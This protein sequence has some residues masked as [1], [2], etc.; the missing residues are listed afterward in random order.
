MTT[1]EELPGPS[2]LF[3]PSAWTD[4]S[5]AF[6]VGFDGSPASRA[7]ARYGAIEARA[8]GVRLTLVMVLDRLEGV[9]TRASRQAD[10][11]RWSNVIADRDDLVRLDPDLDVR[12]DVQVGDAAERLAARSSGQAALVVGQ[13]LGLGTTSRNVLSR[14]D[15]PVV[16]V[17]AGWSPS[18]RPDPRP[19]LL[20]VVPDHED[21]T[22]RAAQAFAG[23]RA[24]RYGVPLRVVTSI[25]SGPDE[26]AALL[27][28]VGAQL[29]VL[30]RSTQDAFHPP[31]SVIDTVLRVAGVPVAVVPG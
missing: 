17:P 14:S 6:V 1:V 26:T 3:V 13:D 9:P 27:E 25:A 30:G 12:I 4:S 7:A 21:A 2:D 28:S 15:V 31:G 18:R 29:I 24:E 11:R 22:S 16:V 20:G 19:I 5:A 8:C 10:A 23:D